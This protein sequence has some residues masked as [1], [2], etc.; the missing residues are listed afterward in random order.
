MKKYL[1]KF[2]KKVCKKWQGSLVKVQRIKEIEPNA[3]KYMNNLARAGSI[4]RIT[5]GWYWIPDDIVDI[6]EF[7]RK[8]KNFKI[9]S[10]Q[11]A[12][13]FWNYDFIHRETYCVKVVDKS[14][15]KA[16][17]EFAERKGWNLKIDY[18]EDPIQVKY[19]KIDGLNVESIE[20][21]IIDCLQ[22]WA[23]TDAFAT[24]YARRG[25]LKFRKLSRESYWKRIPK[26]NIRVRQ[27]LEYGAQKI[28]NLIEEKIFDTK[29][30]V[31]DDE[32]IKNE[33]DEAVEK[34]IE[35]A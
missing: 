13:S 5:W 16:L 32:F 15:G 22:S 9:I 28:N 2:Y 4:E 7:L 19:K 3:K 11:T 1:D 26:S 25:D 24:L 31:I 12:A 6:M 21:T 17:D 27:V 8:D 29:R 23:F 30:S 10:S 20:D 35:F 14:F 33:V 18:I 34:V